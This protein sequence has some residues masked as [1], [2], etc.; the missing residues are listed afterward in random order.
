MHDRKNF[1][2]PI[3]FRFDGP[4]IGKQTFDFWQARKKAARRRGQ[5]NRVQ[6]ARL[7]QIVKGLILADVV[8]PYARRNFDRHV[9]RTA[10]KPM[11]IVRHDAVLML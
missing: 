4:C 10:T 5:G 11:D 2:L 1:C 9:L 6:L 3:V 8:D 7:K